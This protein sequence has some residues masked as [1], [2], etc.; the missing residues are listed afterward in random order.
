LEYPDLDN[1]DRSRDCIDEWMAGGDL[2]LTASL[3]ERP[4]RPLRG[5]PFRRSMMRVVI[6]TCG[7]LV[8][9]LWF[10]AF[11]PAR[12]AVP[13]QGGMIVAASALSD[14]IVEEGRPRLVGPTAMSVGTLEEGLVLNPAID[15][16]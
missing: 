2:D 9:A 7:I 10:A 8:G 14:T 1:Q 4:G 16:E 6:V 13:F 3:Q 11:T 15:A 5:G 12:A